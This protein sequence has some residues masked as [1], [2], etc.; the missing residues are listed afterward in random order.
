MAKNYYKLRILEYE[1]NV[2]EAVQD[3]DEDSLYEIGDEIA[4]P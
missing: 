1:P 3:A 4:V 2:G